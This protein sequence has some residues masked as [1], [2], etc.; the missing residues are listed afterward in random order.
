MRAEVQA[1]LREAGLPPGA[2]VPVRATRYRAVLDRV[3]DTFTTGGRWTGDRRPLWTELKGHVVSAQVGDGPST[4]ALLIPGPDAV[5]LLLEDWAGT[6]AEGHSWVFEGEARAAAAV[7]G[8]LFHVEYAVVARDCSWLLCEN[9]HGVMT[10]VGDV[11]KERFQALLAQSVAGLA[12]P[13][14]GGRVS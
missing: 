10:A 6:K 12:A 5:W 4:V 2:L 7:L 3:L 14:Q 13:P 1:A 9:H 11:M 8:Q